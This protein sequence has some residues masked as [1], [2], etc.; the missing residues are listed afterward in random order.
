MKCGSENQG[1]WDS[2]FIERGERE[3]NV[4]GLL[5]TGSESLINLS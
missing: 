3:T 5:H 4:C 1:G 2:C